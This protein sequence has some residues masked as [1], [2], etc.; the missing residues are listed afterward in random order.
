MTFVGIQSVALG[1][2]VGVTGREAHAEHLTPEACAAGAELSIAILRKM[3]ETP[4]RGYSTSCEW[5]RPAQ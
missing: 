1:G 3:A 5:Q 4:G 2:S